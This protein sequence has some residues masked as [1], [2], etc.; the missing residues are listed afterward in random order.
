MNEINTQEQLDYLTS[1]SP[2]VVD[3]YAPWCGPCRS[4]MPVVEE[5][6]KENKD[7]V[8]VK[9]NIDKAQKLASKYRVSSIPHL[10]FLDKGGKVN[11]TIIGLSSKNNIQSKIDTLA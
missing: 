2:T 5:I 1:I 4:L 8:V 3:F 11:D 7:I 9:C 6:A 10:V